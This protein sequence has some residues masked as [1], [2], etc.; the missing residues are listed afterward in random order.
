MVLNSA[1]NFV[2]LWTRTYRRNALLSPWTPYNEDLVVKFLIKSKFYFAILHWTWQAFKE[3]NTVLLLKNYFYSKTNIKSTRRYFDQGMCGV[4][5]FFCWACVVDTD[6]KNFSF[7]TALNRTLYFTIQYKIQSPWS[8][9]ILP[10]VQK[11]CCKF[12]KLLSADHLNIVMHTLL[13]CNNLDIYIIF[14]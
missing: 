7:P 8:K 3:V 1:S 4:E 11:V 12:A 13:L 5:N 6:W 9:P 14:W 10:T 2:T